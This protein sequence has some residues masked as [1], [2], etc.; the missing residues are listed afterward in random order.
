MAALISAT[1]SS[2]PPEVL[3]HELFVGLGN[4]LE[5][6]LAVLGGLVGEVGG[7]DLLDGRLGADLDGAAPGDGLHLD[8]VDD[9]V[10]GILGAIGSCRTSGFAPR[11]SMI[12][13]TVK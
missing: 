13:C 6:L 7:G 10:E 2:S 1:V 5:Q 8:Q 12:V 11:R 4:G 9:A 3:L